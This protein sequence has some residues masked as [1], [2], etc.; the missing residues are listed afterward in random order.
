MLDTRNNFRNAALGRCVF[1]RRS[2]ALFSKYTSHTGTGIGIGSEM[3]SPIWTLQLG[4]VW[5][6]W[7]QPADYLG[8]D[9][10]NTGTI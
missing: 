1:L 5:N 7:W 6:C 3:M 2:M 8:L 9:K 10:Q 4:C